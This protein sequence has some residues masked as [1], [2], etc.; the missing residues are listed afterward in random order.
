VF[1]FFIQWSFGVTLWEM[2]TL[3]LEPYSDIDPF[4]M[5]SYLKQGY[6]VSQP[7]NCPNEL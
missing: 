5:A 1:L 6:R 4:E 7:V 2:M 3:G